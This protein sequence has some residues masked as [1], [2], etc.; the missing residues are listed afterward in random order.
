MS[1]F[2]IASFL[3]LHGVLGAAAIIIIALGATAIFGS[4]DGE[5]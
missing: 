3:G 2:V 4:M 5:E 1:Q